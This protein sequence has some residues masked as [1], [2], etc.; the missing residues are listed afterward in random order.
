LGLLC[1]GLLFGNP[2]PAADVAYFGVYKGRLFTQTNAGAPGLAAGRPF[3]WN[4]V[5]DPAASNTVLGVMVQPP[6]G[7]PT[8]L[9]WDTNTAMF[10]FGD[11]QTNQ[12]MLDAVYPNGNYFFTINTVHEGIQTPWVLLPSSPYPE[13]L[14]VCNFD[15]AQ[16]VAANADFTLTWTPI[17]GATDNDRIRLYVFDAQRRMVFGLLHGGYLQGT[18]TNATILRNTLADGQIYRGYL[19]YIKVVLAQTNSYPGVYSD[20]SYLA[21]TEFVLR[22]LRRP[23]LAVMAPLPDGSAPLQLAGESGRAYGLETSTNLADWT[24]QLTTNA[25]ADTFAILNCD[26]RQSP[27]RFYRA[28]VLAGTG[29]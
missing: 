10:S 18:T 11:A 8:S 6:L 27:F 5:L 17:V 1:G 23:R 7:V 21:R 28:R 4:A 16:G 25:P 22:T 29:P 24:L 9:P 12:A 19:Y 3:V 20:A 15:A 26:P 13:P 2:V 14:Q